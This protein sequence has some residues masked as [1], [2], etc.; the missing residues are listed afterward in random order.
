MNPTIRPRSAARPSSSSAYISCPS[1]CTAPAEGV[2]RPASSARSVDLPDPETPTMA[3]ASPARTSKL[4]SASMVSSVSPVLTCFARPVT[5]IMR[6]SGMFDIALR[7]I[8]ACALTLSAV[9]AS[10]ATILVYGD[11]LSAGYGLPGD[12]SWVHLLATRLRDERFDYKVANASISGETTLGGRNRIESALSASRPDIVILALGANDG[13][14]GGSLDAMRANL[15]AM[16]DASRRH[17]AQVLLAGM[18]L[19]PNYGAAYTEK[20]RLVFSEVAKSRKTSFIPFLL[21]GFADQSAYFLADGVHPASA[22]QPLILET[23]WKEL[24]PLLRKRVTGD[25]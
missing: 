3:I 2:S 11:S 17:N 1:I 7:L 4:T 25:T 14:R 19:P 10:A 22:A 18:R 24:K 12:K 23:V 9:T 20:F 8:V 6:C 16:V 5:L 15:E 21:D 13:L